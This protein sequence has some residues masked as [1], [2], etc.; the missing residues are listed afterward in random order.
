M[1]RRKAAA[2]PP[3]VAEIDNQIAIVRDNLRQLVEQAASS[4]GAAN[5]EL[6]SQRITEQEAKLALLR[7]QR[8]EA[9]S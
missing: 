9:A 4:S 6:L 7:K 3:A 2:T 8:E 5:E 1:A